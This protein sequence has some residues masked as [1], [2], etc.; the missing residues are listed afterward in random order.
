MIFDIT[1]DRG[2]G[3]GCYYGQ[4]AGPNK[5]LIEYATF[6]KDSAPFDE[7]DDFFEATTEDGSEGCWIRIDLVHYNTEPDAMFR[8]TRSRVGTIKTLN[9]GRKAWQ[10]M[11][12]LA[13]ELAYLANNDAACKVLKRA[14]Q[15]AAEAAAETETE[16]TTAP[17][18]SGNA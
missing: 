8:Y 18:H 5:S 7:R 12:A 10:D 17:D 6:V 3:I 13:G 11:G 2:T 16:T 9:E 14:K 4:Y 15:L 1:T